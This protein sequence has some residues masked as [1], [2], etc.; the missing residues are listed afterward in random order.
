MNDLDSGDLAPVAD[1]RDTSATSALLRTIESVYTPDSL[2]N[3][4]QFRGILLFS[5]PSTFP[6]ISSKDTYFEGIAVSE[7]NSPY[8]TLGSSHYYYYYVLIPEIEPRPIDFDDQ[9][10]IPK[11]LSTFD[12]VGMSPELVQQGQNKRITPGT[13]VT[14]QFENM[15]KLKNPIITNIGPL[16]FNFDITGLTPDK[17]FP[18]GRTPTL[19]GLVGRDGDH[20]D[21]KGN[22][23]MT[24]AAHAHLAA[25]KHTPEDIKECADKYDSDSLIG[26]RYRER[27]DIKISL[28]NPEAQPFCKCFIVRCH[29]Q[30]ITIMLNSTTRTIKWQSDHRRWYIEGS[31][32]QTIYCAKSFASPKVTTTRVVRGTDG[33]IGWPYGG[34]WHQAGFAWDFNPTITLPDGSTKTLKNSSASNLWDTSGIGEIAKGLNMYW[35]GGGPTGGDIDDQIHIGA[36]SIVKRLSDGKITR[37]YQAMQ[38]EKEQGSAQGGLDFEKWK[39][40]NSSDTSS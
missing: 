5:K 17:D 20:L 37:G 23:G 34:S 9:E 16:L 3:K 1:R 31:N 14:V 30:K 12:L 13:Q 36:Q 38:A 8:Q 15:E 33:E 35:G 25:P 29:E 21:P 40:A 2:R 18:Y 39:E 4:N 27:N 11:R 19:V 7:A 24:A 28:L 10:S 6:L 26:G 32:K 22:S